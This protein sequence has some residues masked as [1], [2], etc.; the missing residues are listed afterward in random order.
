MKIVKSKRVS[1]WIGQILLLVLLLSAL[2]VFSLPYLFMI[3]NSFEQ[4]SFS[5]PYPPRIIPKEFIFDAYQ[6]IIQLD[7]FT[8]AFRNSIMNT[9]LTVAIEVVIATLSAYGFARIR[10]P[11]REILFKIYLFTLMV[12]GFLNIIPQF[13]TL[14]NIRLPMEYFANGL[15]GTRS[16]LILIYVATGICGYTFFLRGF[17][18]GLPD[19]LAESVIID[20]G[21]HRTIFTKIM[22]PLS[23]PALG[24][25]TLFAL[26][27][28]WE[29]YF[30]AKVL[31]GSNEAMIT[32]PMLLQRL[33]GQHATRWEWVFAASIITQIP[34]IL[35]FILFQK[36]AVVGG[37][38]EGS[39]K[40]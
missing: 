6:Y 24:T 37:L 33:N 17:F 36:K 30:T 16:G 20:G 26:Q 14:S 8:T 7:I 21:T 32:L 34:V 5:L 31:L 10:F 25:M 4:F 12:P 27:G 2:T 13:V 19:A 15:V 29:E 35:L 3:T 22:L 18:Q 23:K 40:E 39:I 11:G 1:E 38:S 28:F 9:L